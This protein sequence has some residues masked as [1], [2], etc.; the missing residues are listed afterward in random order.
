M[1]IN[2]KMLTIDNIADIRIQL[3]GARRCG[4]IVGF[5][6]TMGALH[7]GHES[8][9]RHARSQA[10]FVVVSIF[11]NPT[12]FGP[13]EDFDKYPRTLS[14]DLELCRRAGADVVFT[15]SVQTMY[16]VPP[17]ATVAM[18]SLVGKLC[19]LSRPGHFAGVCLVVAKLFNIIQPDVAYF[20]AK[21]FQQARIIRRMVEDLNFPV[22][23]EICPTVRQEDGLAMSSRNSYLSAEH[24]RQA[25]ALHGALELAERMIRVKVNKPPA[26]MVIDAMLGYLA[27]QAPDGVVDYV[28]IVD[29]DTLEDVKD[30]SQ[31]VL[32]ALA[33]AFGQTRLI[34]NVL[35]DAY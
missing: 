9:I 27:R 34:D 12:Q 1:H 18:P 19:G 20:G 13:A 30:T 6:P 24:R 31:G 2:D 5:V 21:D 16:P 3:A 26:G 23:I 15:P 4:A 28:K 35:I 25:A 17:A 14:A 22:K 8:L 7:A 32:V 11:V 33:V 29:P 10:G